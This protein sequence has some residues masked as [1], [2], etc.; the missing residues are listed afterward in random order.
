MKPEEEKMVTP[1]IDR[2][3]SSQMS[4]VLENVVDVYTAFKR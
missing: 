1:D 4:V 3:E 2:T